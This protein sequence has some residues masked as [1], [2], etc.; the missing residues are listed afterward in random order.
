MEN[1]NTVLS[2]IDYIKILKQFSNDITADFIVVGSLSIRE[3]MGIDDLP[4]NDIDLVIAK[5]RTDIIAKLMI[6]YHASNKKETTYNTTGR[7][8]DFEY[9]GVLFNVFLE[10]FMDRKV[11]HIHDMWFSTIWAT[12]LAKKHYNRAKDLAYINLLINK[13]SKKSL[14]TM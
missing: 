1:T 8:I 12:I 9:K 11:V 5:S 4:V 2:T 10:E 6:L 13:L 3:L 14:K 7:R